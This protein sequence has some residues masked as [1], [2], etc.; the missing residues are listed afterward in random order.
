MQNYDGSYFDVHYLER[1]HLDQIASC[2]LSA[3]SQ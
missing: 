3:P 1:L 2:N